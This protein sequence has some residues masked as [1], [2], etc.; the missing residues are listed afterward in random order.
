MRVRVRVRVGVGVGVGVRGS[1][2]VLD[3]EAALLA[4]E[5]GQVEGEARRVVQE[6]GVLA[7]LGLG[8]GFGFGFG[9]GFG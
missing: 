3:L 5:L 1:G 6:E 8:L 9:F 2:H 4:H 7:C